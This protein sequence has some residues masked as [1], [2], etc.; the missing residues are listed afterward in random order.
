[1]NNK[2]KFIISVLG[3]ISLTGCMNYEDSYPTAYET[4]AYDNTQFYPTVDYRMANYGSDSQPYRG[5]GSGN[6]VVPDSYHVG[7]SHS[8]V[9]FKDRDKNWVR[10]QNPQAYTIEVADNPKASQVAQKLYKAPKNDRRAQVKYYRNG[11]AYYKGVYGSYDSPEAAQKALDS[12]PQEIKQG[13]GV[14]NWRN[15][16]GSLND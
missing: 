6:V 10:S 5:Q 1:M 4:Y 16:Q 12:L 14:T 7:E 11:Q 13:A 3:A 9:S 8:P 2:L 15:V